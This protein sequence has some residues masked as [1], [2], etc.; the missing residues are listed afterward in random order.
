MKRLLLFIS[1]LLCANVL[2]A[3]TAFWIDSLRYEITSTNPAEV[4]VSSNDLSITIAIIPET[5][6]YNG[7][8]YSVTS[9]GDWAFYDCI[10]LTSVTIP[11]SV[12]SIGELA[13][14]YCI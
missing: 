13:F 10:G 12:T 7:I 3:Q 11:N 4:E 14:M 5:V 8:N 1:T 2:L 6:S 9:I